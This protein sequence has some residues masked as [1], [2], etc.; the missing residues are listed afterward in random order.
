MMKARSVR[1]VLSAS[2]AAVVL[3]FG[4]ALVGLVIS[5]TT[6]LPAAFTIGNVL[7]SFAPMDGVLIVSIEAALVFLMIAGGVK[8][9]LSQR[10]VRTSRRGVVSRAERPGPVVV[11]ASSRGARSAAEATKPRHL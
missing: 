9:V 10:F 7:G 11:S 3:V 2:V 8:V 6:H 4:C 5:Q 1:M